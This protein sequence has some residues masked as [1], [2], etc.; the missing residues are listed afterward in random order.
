M[1]FSRYLKDLKQDHPIL[2]RRPAHGNDYRWDLFSFKFLA[3]DVSDC[4]GWPMSVLP[5]NDFKVMI[6]P[7]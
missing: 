2:L 3:T 1:Y 4:L 6:H 5:I 7:H